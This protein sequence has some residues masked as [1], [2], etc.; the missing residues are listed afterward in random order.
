MINRFNQS[1]IGIVGG[2]NFCRE[3]LELVFED[4]ADFLHPVILGV[5][6]LDDKAPGLRYARARGIFTT[7]NFYDLYQLKDIDLLIEL[8]YDHTLIDIINSTKPDGLRL[9]DHVMA[10]SLWSLLQIEKEKVITF[11]EIKKAPVPV[12]LVEP[13][14]NRYTQRIATIVR[15]RNQRYQDIEHSLI[16]SERA[17][18]QIIQGSTIPTFIINKDHIVTHWNKACERLTGYSADQIVGTNEHWRPFRRKKRPLVADLILDG[19]SEKEAWRY[20]DTRWRRSALIDGAFEAEEYFPH[21]G[22]GQWLFFT[23]SPIKAQDGTIIGAIETLWDI[24]ADKRAEEERERHTRELAESERTMAQIIQGSTIPT[25]VIDRDHVITHWNKALENL[26]GY[27]AEEMVGTRKQWVPFWEN[28]RPSMADV[29]I[30]QISGEELEVLYGENWRKSAL[31]ED[32]YEAEKFFP[33]LGESG[34][35]CFF[36]AAPIKGPDGTIIGAIETFQDTT[37]DKKAEEERERYTSE[38]STLCSIYS[39]LSAPSDIDERVEFAIREVTDFLEADAICIYIIGDDGKFHMKH[40]LGLS[41]AACRQGESAGEDTLVYRVAQTGHFTLY[42]DLPRDCADEVCVLEQEKLRSL[43]YVP[44]STKE[45]NTFGV[46][47]IASHKLRHFS[48][49]TKNILELIGNRIGVAIENVTLQRQYIRSE[50]KYRSLFN[51]APNSSFIL[52]SR[53]LAIID[54]NPRAEES[55]GYSRKELLG[56]SFSELGDSSDEELLKGMRS[57]SNGQSVLFT[58]KRHYRKSGKP[59]YVTITISHAE[60]G[61]RDVLIVSTTDITESV[62]RET[63]L[64][65]ASKMTTLGQMAAGIAHEINQPLNVIQVCADFMSKMLNK[66][67]R[68]DDESLRTLADDFTRNVQRATGIIEHMRAFARQ[69]EVVRNKVDINQPIMDVFKVLG[70]QIKSHQVKLELD[71]DNRIPPILAEHNR[72]EQV[73]IN[74]VTNAIDAMDEKAAQ[75]DNGVCEKTL[76]IQTF[77]DN[78]NVVATV[79]DT[80][81]GMTREVLDK[82][83][84]PFFTTK[85]VGKGTGLGVSIS[86][87]IIK[88]YNGE[89]E[90]DSE[91]G[92]GTTFMLRFPAV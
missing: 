38:L 16:K 59:F 91:I 83:F 12:D 81:T 55:Y 3:L 1:R 70:H 2:G 32:A 44:I 77:S 72:L 74:L 58:K 21:L 52:D 63:Q 25:F 4:G 73:F 82:V 76:R 88:D 9:V 30:D 20:Y 79:T 37:E 36:T 50:E 17:M 24:T 78:D 65:Q 71:L 69:S 87:G 14:F 18:S 56:K 46:I 75:S 13:I 22:D 40:S 28:E 39:A 41:E 90:I 5:A 15:K 54:T 35:W 29:I 80:G 64:I 84:E 33:R 8:T 27:S 62:E 66:G 47:R 19:V 86:Y 68:I 48:E 42:E 7:D 51:H 57:I 49:D 23:A 67:A 61:T 53:T 10:R 85:E 89:I 60:Y 34:R 31:I 6:D 45:G 26:T 11:G 92:R 43:A